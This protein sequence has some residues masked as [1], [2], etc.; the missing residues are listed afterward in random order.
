M[1]G[2]GVEIGDLEVELAGLGVPV[3]GKVAVDVLHGG[4]FAEMVWARAMR[5]DANAAAATRARARCLGM[6]LL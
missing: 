5:A 2:V 4:G 6:R 3:E 1:S